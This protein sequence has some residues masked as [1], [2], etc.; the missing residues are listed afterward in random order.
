MLGCVFFSLAASIFLLQCAIIGKFG[1]F[2]TARAPPR[3]GG[4]AIL[5]TLGDRQDVQPPNTASI[6][7]PR[8]PSHASTTPELW[9]CCEKKHRKFGI[10]PD[11]IRVLCPRSTQQRWTRTLEL[12]AFG[13]VRGS[14]FL[15]TKVETSAGCA[16]GELLDS[17]AHTHTCVCVTL[18]PFQSCF[19]KMA[20]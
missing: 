9:T 2:Q 14:C 7:R 1:A 16:A 10:G 12:K 8:S 18:L 6:R 17:K 15:L 11:I 3:A 20:T 5:T 4:T 19:S 13:G